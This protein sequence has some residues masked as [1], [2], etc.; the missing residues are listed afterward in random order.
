MS[1]TIL[2]YLLKSQ[3]QLQVEQVEKSL[4]PILELDKRLAILMEDIR[5]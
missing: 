5:K 1:I 3:S 4:L 2:E